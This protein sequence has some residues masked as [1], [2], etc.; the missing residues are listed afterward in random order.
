[1]PA[2]SR[3]AP[4]SPRP[5]VAALVASLAAVVANAE[6]PPPYTTVRIDYPSASNYC[7]H[8]GEWSGNLKSA[9]LL[10]R[11][12]IRPEDLSKHA[13]IFVGYRRRGDPDRLWLLTPSQ[14]WEPYSADSA[15]PAAQVG[16]VLQAVHA[17]PILDTPTDLAQLPADGEVWVGYG[18][19]LN[20]PGS[21]TR[22]SF[23]H[24]LDQQ[25]FTRIWS[26]EAPPP[27]QFG[28]FT[29]LAFSQVMQRVEAQ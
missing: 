28:S 26:V 9:T 13:D 4:V 16:Q 14:T 18:P 2:H 6:S 24:M 29:C 8:T 19:R 23:R 1:M 21:S 7:F 3:M 12:V 25:R 17:V 15:P 5:C 20:A 27:K 22:D 11:L 10:Y